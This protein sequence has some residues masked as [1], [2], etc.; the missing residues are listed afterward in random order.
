MEK[1]AWRRG[2]FSRM[3]EDLFMVNWELL[4]DGMDVYEC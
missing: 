2:D 4:F 1:L 3:S